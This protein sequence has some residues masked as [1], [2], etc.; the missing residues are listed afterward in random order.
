M[1][2]WGSASFARTPGPPAARWRLQPREQWC[3]ARGLGGAGRPF[4]RSAQVTDGP[5]AEPRLPGVFGLAEALTTVGLDV[6]T[7]RGQRGHLPPAAVR[8][9]P[10][11]SEPALRE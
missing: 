6:T 1:G 8:G 2:Y 5:H 3:S 4:R 9:G 10:G 11:D 7:F